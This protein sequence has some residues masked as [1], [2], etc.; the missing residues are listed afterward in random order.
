MYVWIS[1]VF[2]QTEYRFEF[3]YFSFF[4]LLLLLWRHYNNQAFERG[5]SGIRRWCS[6]MWSTLEFVFGFRSPVLYLNS[7]RIWMWT[8]F[9]FV[10]LCA[11]VCVYVRVCN[12][13]CV[14]AFE[15]L[16][17]IISMHTTKLSEILIWILDTHRNYLFIKWLSHYGHSVSYQFVG[18][19][20]I[21]HILSTA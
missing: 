12:C 13:G 6:E 8:I 1:L 19:F 5:T 11:C 2:K 21:K 17:N 16:D 15:F 20:I 18:L 9:M 10:Q 3:I 7:L 14:Y 4:W